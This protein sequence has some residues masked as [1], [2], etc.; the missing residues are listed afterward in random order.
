M[1]DFNLPNN[2]RSVDLPF[3]A[4][5]YSDVKAWH[6]SLAYAKAYLLV[7]IFADA[8]LITA[9]SYTIHAY[10]SVEYDIKS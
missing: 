2:S 6:I 5:S 10:I 9:S 8:L 4:S 3:E 1:K 7:A